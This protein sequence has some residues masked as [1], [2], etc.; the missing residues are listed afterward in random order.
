MRRLAILGGL[1]VV[2]CGIA[3]IIAGAGVAEFWRDFV[4]FF[5][6]FVTILGLGYT[7]YQVT[8]IETA[9]LAAQKAAQ[10]RARKVGGDCFSS[11]RLASTG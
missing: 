5:S 3:L 10:D 9:A 11:P 6:L 2:A 4:G 7:V 1:A 8:L